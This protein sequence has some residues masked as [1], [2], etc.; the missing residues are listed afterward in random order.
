M[1]GLQRDLSSGAVCTCGVVE[2]VARESAR[3]APGRPS[4][5]GSEDAV[6]EDAPWPRSADVPLRPLSTR[7]PLRSIRSGR[8][9]ILPRV[10][11]TDVEEIVEKSGHVLT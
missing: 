4:T 3:S 11:R 9:V 1:L 2:Q 6:T 10:I 8:R 7:V 5:A